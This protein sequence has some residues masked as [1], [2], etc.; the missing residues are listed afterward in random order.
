MQEP[1]PD[2]IGR[3]PATLKEASG[4]PNHPVAH[5]P[6]GGGTGP[7]GVATDDNVVA[8]GGPS[9]TRRQ[10][11]GGDLQPQS[12]KPLKKLKKVAPPIGS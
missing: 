4:A 11:N 2:G 7:Q 10:R 1:L 3:W 6:E 9:T 5:A 8:A 12:Q